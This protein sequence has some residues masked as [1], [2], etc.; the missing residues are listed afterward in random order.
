MNLNQLCLRY[1]PNSKQVKVRILNKT[2]FGLRSFYAK[3]KELFL[4]QQKVFLRG[5][6]ECCIF[7]LTGYP[8]T[9]K[10]SWLKV[11]SVAKAHGLNHLR[12]HSWCPPEAA[13]E[14]ADDLGFMLQI[15]GPFWAEFGKD[16]E[17]DTYAYAE[18]ERI[19]STY[20]N[21]PSFCM[22]AISNEP[23]GKNMNLFFAEII[24]H[25]RKDS[26]CV[27]TSGAGGP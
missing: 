4:N 3:G 6:L 17:L 14:A 22:L 19:L 10:I 26:R 11:M 21:H 13:F 12:F 20:G 24:Q 9:D 7:P 27:Y 18:C 23:S 15:E 16:T 2:T 25:L 5:T 1:T 8:P